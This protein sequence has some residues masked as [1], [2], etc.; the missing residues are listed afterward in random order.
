MLFFG[1]ALLYSSAGFGGGS[2]YLAVL[3][4]TGLAYT[5]IRATSLLCNIIVV[6]SGTYIYHKN[7]LV[8][9]K[10]ILPLVLAS[11]PLAFVGGWIKI[12]QSTFFILL[13]ISLLVASSLMLVSNK[14]HLDKNKGDKSNLKRDMFLGSGI[15]FL[16]GIVGIGGGIFLAPLLHFTKWDIP[17]KIAA[18]ASV[19]I[20]LNSIT[21]L[22][23][24]SLNPNFNLDYPLTLSLLIAV[25]VGGQIG[26]RLSANMLSQLWIKRI[27]AI[28]I[29][30]VGF[31]TL[32]NNIL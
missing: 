3:V 10:K 31:R 11:M 14:N 29:A 17:K 12:S 5:E 13:G 1:I 7:G 20:L 2:S 6:S 27:T 8:N 24:Q 26:S 19:F 16:S 4:L 9:W 30:I 32:W 28:V 18:T 25:F 15:G 23:G 21:G 22:I